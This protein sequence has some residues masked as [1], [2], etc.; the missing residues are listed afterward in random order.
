MLGLLDD[1][2]RYYETLHHDL[3]RHRVTKRDVTKERHSR[4]LEYDSHKRFVCSAAAF[5][6]YL[7]YSQ[8]RFSD[9]TDGWRFGVAV[10]RWSRST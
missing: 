1:R 8:L 6:V 4:I 3:L 10:T 9:T 7:S 5:I 2:L